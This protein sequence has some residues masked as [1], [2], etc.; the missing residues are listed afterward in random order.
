L[1]S[2]PNRRREARQHRLEIANHPFR[3]LVADA[4]R[5]A[6]TPSPARRRDARPPRHDAQ[7]IGG[8]THDQ[9]PDHGVPESRTIQGSV[10]REQRQQRYVMM[11]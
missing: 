2:P 4:H 11:P 7:S 8:K 6:A 5:I 9:K 1:K 3:Q 10:I